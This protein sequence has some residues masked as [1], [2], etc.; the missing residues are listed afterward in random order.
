MVLFFYDAERGQGPTEKG[1]I[2]TLV[3]PLFS[4][5]KQN[6]YRKKAKENDNECQLIRR[7]SVSLCS[8]IQGKV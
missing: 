7:W 8:Y 6:I 1:I 2:M 5:L 4:C 3:S